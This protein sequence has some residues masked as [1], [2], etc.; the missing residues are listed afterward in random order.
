[1]LFW[2]FVF[3]HPTE[4]SV[5]CVGGCSAA[6]R[7]QR[8]PRSRVAQLLT[9]H[10]TRTCLGGEEKVTLRLRSNSSITEPRRRQR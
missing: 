5:S 1:M 3:H 8:A 6:F 4:A 7:R 9:A 2:P 10:R